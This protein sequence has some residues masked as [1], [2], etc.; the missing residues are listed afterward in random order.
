[1]NGQSY[2]PGNMVKGEYPGMVT[3]NE[4][5]VHSLN[6]ATIALAQ[7]VGYGNVAAL[8][9]SAGISNARATPSVAIGAYDATPI[10][11]AGAYTVFANNGVHIDPWML[12]SVR[13]A[14]GDIVADFS[15]QARQVLD[16]RVAYLTQSLM[17]NVI[18]HGTGYTVRARGFTAPAAGKT[19]TEHDAWFAG[20]T[21]NLLCVVWVGNDDYTDIKLQGAD[22]AAPI[23]AE[24]MKSAVKLPE[25]SD[26][27]PF[28]PPEGVT[29]VTLD[30]NT[31]L[32]A[33]ASCP[34]DF[35]VAFLDGT[36]P[37][38]FCSQMGENPQNFLQRLFGVGAHPPAV[39]QNNP[40]APGSAYPSHPGTNPQV[41]ARPGA[42]P[43]PNGTSPEGNN[44]ETA[45]PQ[46][47]KRNFF[48]KLFGI[49]DNDNNKKQEQQQ[50]PQ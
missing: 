29:T 1:I 46:K 8:A 25:Y 26:T 37:Q 30:K 18:N 5:L 15:P 17:E 38:N 48:Q 47:K 20:Y 42:T 6:I 2:M 36:A 10:D 31:D 3:A 13:N 50:Q 34:D 32:L 21:S 39:Q 45:E 16:P 4:A 23:W 40:A 49:G 27:K 41:P 43:A 24:F 14:N 11:M 44:N 7:Q 12:A 22:A 35:T 33:D 28:T 19:G 9:R